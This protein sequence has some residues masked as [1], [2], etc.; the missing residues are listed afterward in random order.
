VTVDLVGWL[1][2]AVF[3]T[4]YFT[5]SSIALRR[6]QG[7]AATLWATYGILIHAR[8]VIMANVLVAVVAVATSFRRV[9]AAAP[10]SAPTPR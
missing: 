2:T 4:S 6:I 7:I 5:T 8:P 1:A 3:M 10:P 9:T